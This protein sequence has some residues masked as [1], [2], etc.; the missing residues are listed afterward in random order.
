MEKLKT[1]LVVFATLAMGACIWFCPTVSTEVSFF[2]ILL[3]STYLGLDI[4]GMIKKTKELPD[5]QFKKI[6]T[7]RYWIC[8][9]SLFLLVAVNAFV[10]CKMPDIK[11]DGTFGTLTAALF[12][13]ISAYI[14]ALE[15]NKLVTGED[16]EELKEPEKETSS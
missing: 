10:V 6:K 13:V 14:G 12:I 8:G 11:N 15:G 16:I 1:L 3:L 5:G 4:W 9:V 2:Y 7:W